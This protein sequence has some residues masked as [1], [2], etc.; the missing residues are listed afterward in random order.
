MLQLLKKGS[1]VV[2][3]FRK[4]IQ[5]F[6]FTYRELDAFIYDAVVL[7]YLVGEDN[8][9]GL[10]T[11]GSWYA[12]TGYGFA[13]PKNSKYLEKFNKKMIEYRESGDLERLR[14]YWFQGACKSQ[15]NK[16]NMSK[17]LDINQFM[18]AFLLLGCGIL[19][20]VILL[21]LEHLY[22]SYCRRY[23]AKTEKAD[24]FALVS[25][26]SDFRFHIHNVVEF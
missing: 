2:V 24:C 23:L 14:R 26:V 1:F 10:L 7:D 18:S 3:R 11:V 20:T 25:L 4:K 8:D 21:A 15:K 17:P 9:C 6:L 5:I 13:M 19:L 22:F 16:R 12:M